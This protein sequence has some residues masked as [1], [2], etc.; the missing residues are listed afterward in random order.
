M[1]AF[2]IF[3][4]YLKILLFLSLEEY[5]KLYANMYYDIK[6]SFQILKM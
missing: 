1:K 4:R 2:T 3:L 6:G 5:D